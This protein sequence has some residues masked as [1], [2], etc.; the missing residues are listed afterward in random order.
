MGGL[1][2]SDRDPKSLEPSSLRI[3]F[4]RARN[5]K[6]YN[7]DSLVKEYDFQQ[8]ISVKPGIELRQ[9][10]HKRTLE[11]RALKIIK[12]SPEM[13][14]HLYQDALSVL[15]ATMYAATE[16]KR[17]TELIDTYE[18]QNYIYI[19]SELMSKGDLV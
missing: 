4:N 8:V 10:Q 1:C 7:S 6:I 14:S 2:C 16:H 9:I 5:T 3:A 18:D 19:V 15:I 11:L 17:V 13:K 12:K